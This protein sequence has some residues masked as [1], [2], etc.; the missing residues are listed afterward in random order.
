MNLSSCFVC[1]S[2]FIISAERLFFSKN[3]FT[4]TCQRGPVLTSSVAYAITTP[5]LLTTSTFCHR[6]G[7]I[8]APSTLLSHDATQHSNDAAVK[9]HRFSIL[10]MI[11]STELI[12]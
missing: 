5:T 3:H 12:A 10:I 6:S 8:G 2:T 9:L 1:L 4:F 7:R 11:V